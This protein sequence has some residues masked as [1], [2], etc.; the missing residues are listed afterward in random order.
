MPQDGWAKDWRELSD[1]ASE[2]AFQHS[3]VQQAIDRAVDG[4][5]TSW[6]VRVQQLRLRLANADDERSSLASQI[7]SEE[8][9]REAMLRALRQPAIKLDSVGVVVVSSE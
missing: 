5:N 2:L 1:A 8:A 9:A 4:A 3:T 6:G 7:G